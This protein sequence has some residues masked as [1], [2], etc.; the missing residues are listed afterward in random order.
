M[1]HKYAKFIEKFN[2]YTELDKYL[3]TVKDVRKKGIVFELF[4]Y[5]LL[6]THKDFAFEF[7]GGSESMTEYL[8]SYTFDNM[9]YDYDLPNFDCGAD[10]RANTQTDEGYI[11]CMIQCKF[12]SSGNLTKQTLS[13]YINLMS[14]LDHKRIFN[15]AYGDVVGII[16]T[17]TNISKSVKNE[18]SNYDFDDKDEHKSCGG[19]LIHYIDKTF[20]KNL[21]SDDYN[22]IK[23]ELHEL[24]LRRSHT[25]NVVK[26]INPHNDF[27]NPIGTCKHNKEE[28]INGYVSCSKLL[29]EYPKIKNIPNYTKYK[30]NKDLDRFINKYT[31]TMYDFE[32]CCNNK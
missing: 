12:Q 15:N 10:M 17:N 3:A 21:T 11:P 22:K 14:N 4:S 13:S 26:S 27:S 24:N 2:S 8:C 32:S 19:K 1:I 31:N 9:P 28:N 25:K 7:H 23:K 20:L 16:I 29:E 5:L 6:K 30:Y 18:L